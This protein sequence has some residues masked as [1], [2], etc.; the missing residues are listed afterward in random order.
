MKQ[1]TQML[2]LLGMCTAAA[3]ILS[4]VESFIPSLSPGLKIGLPNIVI[5]FVLYR[6]GWVRAGAVSLIRVLLTA[7]SFGSMLSFAYGAAGAV[8]SLTV[9]ALLRRTQLFSAV[10]VSV[11]GGVAHNTAQIIVAA[12]VMGTRQV[13]YYLPLLII[14]GTVA[15][16]LVGIAGG[17]L[18]ARLPQ[19]HAVK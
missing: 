18:L 17:I 11:A 10:G 12:A 3:M 16:I 9:M 13:L 8:L 1:K 19:K 2:A 7:L 14:G 5:V 4:Y 6:F 15:G